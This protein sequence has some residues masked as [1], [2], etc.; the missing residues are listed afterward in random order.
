MTSAIESKLIDIIAD[1]MQCEPAG[2]TSTTSLDSLGVN[3]IELVEILMA[4]EDEYD[5]SIEID[6][7]EAKK[8]LPTVGELIELGKTYGIGE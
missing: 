3:S 5:I 1:T 2:I 4:I 8:N 7:F 6:A